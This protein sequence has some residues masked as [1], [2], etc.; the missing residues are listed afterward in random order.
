MMA[1]SKGVERW[2]TPCSTVPWLQL[3]RISR[4]DGLTLVVR[5]L[6][7][8]APSRAFEFRFEEV[9]VFRI[10]TED[11]TGAQFVKARFDFGPTLEL[12]PSPWEAELR[13]LH[14]EFRHVNNCRHLVIIANRDLIEVLTP[15]PPEV[16]AMSDALHLRSDRRIE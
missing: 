3:V 1:S 8:C 2:E 5:E 16:R 11:F 14:P 4:D 6:A 15:Q 10:S 12:I 13:H 7:A 9:P